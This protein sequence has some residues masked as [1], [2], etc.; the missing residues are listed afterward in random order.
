MEIT[1][2]YGELTVRKYHLETVVKEMLFWTL[3]T[4]QEKAVQYYSKFYVLL[5][6]VLFAVSNNYHTIGKP[7]FKILVN[8]LKQLFKTNAD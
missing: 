2:R 4:L 6:K 7:L 5:F 1:S 8:I 3:P